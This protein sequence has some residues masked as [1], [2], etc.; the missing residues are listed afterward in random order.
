MRAVLS[1]AI[2]VAAGAGVDITG[3]GV[4][5]SG[6]ANAAAGAPQSAQHA[7]ST[8]SEVCD[9]S[10]HPNGVRMIYLPVELDFVYPEFCDV[11]RTG[12]YC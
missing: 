5:C 6:A 4:I 8:R 1:F 9:V 2:D 12:R 7:H 11:L 10:D 3:V